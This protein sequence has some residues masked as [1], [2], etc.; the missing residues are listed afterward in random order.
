MLYK[1]IILW[2]CLTQIGQTLACNVSELDNKSTNAT[3][4]TKCTIVYNLEEYCPIIPDFC[5]D[6][7]NLCECQFDVT[8]LQ[9][10]CPMK[11]V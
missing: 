7:P 2:I 5:F 9:F 11:A 1:L 8:D 10:P 3:L 6:L 4:Y